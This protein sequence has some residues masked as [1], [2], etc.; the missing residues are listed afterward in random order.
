MICLENT[1][2]GTILPLQAAQEILEWA[3]AQDPKIPLHLD[4]ARLWDAVAASAGSLKDYCSCFDSV[5]LCFSKGLGAPVGSIIVGKRA[6]IEKAR[7]FRKSIGGGLRQAGVIAAAAR[8]SVET[9]LTGNLNRSQEMARLVADAWE[10]RGGKLLK[11]RETG[12]VW[13]DLAGRDVSQ[14]SWIKAA[15]Q[16]GVTVLGP[17]VVCHYQNSR[18]AVGRL[19]KAMDIVLDANAFHTVNGD[20]TVSGE[21]AEHKAENLLEQEAS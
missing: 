12:M 9:Y 3:R 10:A 8:I 4:G 7:H 17:R 13:L 19:V 21:A 16:A 11:P 1:L 2:G 14:E 20:S 6:F 15:L 18:E 5:S